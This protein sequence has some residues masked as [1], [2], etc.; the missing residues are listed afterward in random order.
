M[1]RWLTFVAAGPW[2]SGSWA[3]LL[4]IATIVAMSASLA[5]VAPLLLLCSGGLM[6]LTTLR[7]PPSS[8]VRVVAIA[9]GM[10]IAAGFAA[11]VGGLFAVMLFVVFWAPVM[12]AAWGVRSGGLG[13]G[14]QLVI[15]LSLLLAVSG[16]SSGFDPEPLI[17]EY[18]KLM[19][20]Q[21]SD[22]AQSEL[23]IVRFQAIFDWLQRYFWGWLSASFS[24]LWMCALVIGR[25][26]HS[27]LDNSGAFRKEF[28]ALRLGFLPA[29]ALLIAVAAGL[30]SEA[31]PAWEIAGLIG[32]GISWQG[33]ACV[34]WQFQARKTGK[35]VS[36]I[37][38]SVLVLFGLQMALVLMVLG[39]VDTLFNVRTWGLPD[40]SA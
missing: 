14:V 7:Q 6:A 21:V 39:L 31:V 36:W 37:F 28:A 8:L 29:L 24:L 35:L 4:A 9:V 3:A 16:H 17:A 10:L 34:Q 15:V 20:D 5:L 38:Y 23:A 19:V 40:S 12:L 30:N 26:W 2:Q 11:G 25:Y 18:R 22:S 27:I 32:L 13:R 33:L 1:S